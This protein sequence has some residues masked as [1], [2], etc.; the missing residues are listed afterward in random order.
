MDDAISCYFSQMPSGQHPY[1]GQY[2][3]GHPGMGQRHPGPPGM[4]MQGGPCPA[5]GPMK[6]NMGMYARRPA[7]YPNPYMKRPMY[8]NNQMEVSCCFRNYHII[9]LQ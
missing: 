6:Q 8:A 2:P 1:G 9:I 7:P 4:P 3:P 5:P